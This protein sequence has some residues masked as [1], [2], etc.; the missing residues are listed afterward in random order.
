MNILEF[1]AWV[2]VILVL[3]PIVVF[4]G[5]PVALFILVCCI[6]LIGMTVEVVGVEMFLVGLIILFVLATVNRYQYYKNV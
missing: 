1:A 3:G 5:I 2:F 4:I 6:G